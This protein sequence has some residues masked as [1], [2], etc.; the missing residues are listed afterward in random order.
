MLYIYVKIMTYAAFVAEINFLLHFLKNAANKSNKDI[1]DC[2]ASKI[3]V[4]L[5]KIKCCSPLLCQIRDKK[6]L[7]P[8]TAASVIKRD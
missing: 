8:S 5:K 2:C 3:N 4:I 7:R 1:R 6:R